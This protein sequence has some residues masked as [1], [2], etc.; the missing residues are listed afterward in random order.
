M[1]QSRIG[2]NE[3]GKGIILG[4]MTVHYRLHCKCDGL[5]TLFPQDTLEQPFSGQDDPPND[6]LAIG[7]VCHRHKSAET[8]FLSA[9][10]PGW[11]PKDGAE[12]LEN[13]SGDTV[14]VSTLRCEREACKSRLPLFA[15]WRPGTSAEE[16]RA[17]ISTWRWDHLRCP[18]GHS[19]PKPEGFEESA[20]LK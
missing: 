16:R 10:S 17:D 9:K 2:W 5:P 6:F 1:V 18:E 14:H 11:N 4:T 15:Y 13:R 8:Y 3:P 12:V 19:I 20:K 7:V